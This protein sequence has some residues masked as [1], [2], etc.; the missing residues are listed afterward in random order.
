MTLLI[1][2]VTESNKANNII[3]YSTA[4]FIALEKS[5]LYN[6]KLAGDLSGHL[7]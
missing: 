1:N 4:V 7:G 3:Q 6:I 5:L 2:R